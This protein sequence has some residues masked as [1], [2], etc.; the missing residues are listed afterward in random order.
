[1]STEINLHDIIF[2]EDS[3]ITRVRSV[4]S[5]YVVNA[6]TGGESDTCLDLVG[7]DE[8][9]ISV[10]NLIADV[11]ESHTWLDDRLRILSHLSVALSRLAESFIVMSKESLFFTILCSSGSLTVL[12]SIFRNLALRELA[13]W[14]LLTDGDSRRIGLSEGYL[15]LC[16]PVTKKS[17]MGV[18]LSTGSVLNATGAS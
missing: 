5:C 17:D 6:A 12:I 10:F 4:M 8:S 16:L 2:I 13:C 1:M 18:V 7:L 9:A 3:E 11:D 15:S 14:E